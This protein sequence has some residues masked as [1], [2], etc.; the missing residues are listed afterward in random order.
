MTSIC[1]PYLLV[2]IIFYFTMSEC[3]TLIHKSIIT[4]KRCFFNKSYASLFLTPCCAQKTLQLVLVASCAICGK[5]SERLKTLMISIGSSISFNE[6][7][8]FSPNTLSIFGL[9]GII[10]YPAC[11]IACEI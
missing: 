3:A 6:G 4:V 8:A 1:H 11:C 7:Y 2:L 9:T 10:L 5:Y